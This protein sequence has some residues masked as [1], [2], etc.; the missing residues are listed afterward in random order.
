MK[1]FLIVALLPFLSVCLILSSCLKSNSSPTCSDK[2]P[3]EEVSA[4]QAYCFANGINYITDTTGLFYQILD[5]GVDPKPTINSTIKTTYV[6]KMI[7]GTTIDST[8]TTPIQLPLNQLIA[9]WQIGL[10]KIGKG[11]HLKMV[12][13]SALCYGCYGR[14]PNIPPNTILYFD[15]T[16][17]D[18]Q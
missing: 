8:G 17:V 4:M 10:Q 5:P 11:G 1:K 7:T 2:D 18:V 14:S 16:L 15:I 9:A 13:P 3:S 12:A 6:G